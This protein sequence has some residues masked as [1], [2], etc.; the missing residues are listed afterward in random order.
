MIRTNS[1]ILVH[2]LQKYEYKGLHVL[3]DTQTEKLTTM[4]LLWL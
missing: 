4:F 2:D 1:K 3:F